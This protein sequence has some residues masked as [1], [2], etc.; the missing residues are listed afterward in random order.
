MGT[1]ILST[2]TTDTLL[3]KHLGIISHSVNKNIHCTKQVVY[4]NVT[5]MVNGIRKFH[6]IC[7]WPNCLRIKQPDN[8][9]V[10]ISFRSV[11]WLI[12]LGQV[13]WL[14][15]PLG[16]FCGWWYHKGSFVADDTSRA[17]LWLMIPRGQFCG[18]WYHEGSFVADDTTRA[19]LWLMIP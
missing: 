6:F 14:M 12:P 3:L 10:K 15:I 7:I 16:Q 17:V 9:R 19:I 4:K 13:L 11:L 1:Y 18:W 8:P 5:F 2:V